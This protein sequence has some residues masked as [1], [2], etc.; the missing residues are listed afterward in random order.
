M[1]D[2]PAGVDD[3]AGRVALSCLEAGISAAEPSRVVRSQVSLEGTT[4]VVAGDRYDL[5]EYDDVVVIGG[6]KAAATVAVALEAV[7]GEWIARGAVVTDNPADTERI[8]VLPGDH[9]VPSERGVESTQTLL[10]LANGVTA[11]DLV[12]CIVT[13]GGS[14]LLPAPAA[15]I[16]LDALRATTEALLA[17]GASIDEINA[18][19][20]HC[21][22]LKGGQLAAAIGPADVLG[23]VFSDVIGNRLDV[24][25]SGPLTP[26]DST[27][28]DA[29]A[30][31]DR[32]E[33]T[34]PDAVTAR[35]RRGAAG[36]YP[37]TP[38]PGAAV[39]DGVHQYVLADGQTALAGAAEAA[40]DA[41]YQPLK[42]SS[43]I[44]GEASEAA[45]VLSGVPEE[46]LETGHPIEPPAVIL[47]GGETTVTIHG[48]GVGG[49]NQEFVLSAA[50][51]LSAPTVTVAA[52]DTDGIDG[53][54]DAA[55]AIATSDVARP[56]EAARSALRTND[57]GTFLAERDALIRT[58]K[59][60]TN[61]NDLRVFV[62]PDA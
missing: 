56:V 53:A 52:V 13:G 10:E 58:G 17:S 40:R 25:A 5:S 32:Y 35:L 14:A 36:D 31:L 44:R 18:V 39:F 37:E 45:K 19:R 62:V 30:V 4:L 9:P 22:A 27:F 7:L 11:S 28:A 57:S 38:E 54:S 55:G 6:G 24:I 46:T 59:T 51:E 48:D 34:V 3:P 43:R 60:G 26:D 47:T 29:L 16:D 42:L 21:S 41:A 12:I 33:V 23:L 20:K 15:D 61:V 2:E 1:I 50:L 49:P 8:E